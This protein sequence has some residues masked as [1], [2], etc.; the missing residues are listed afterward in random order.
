MKQPES[1]LVNIFQEGE[2]RR[3]L[4]ALLP[5]LAFLAGLILLFV[6]IFQ[7]IMVRVEGQSHSW[8]TAV[9]WTLVTM[10]TLGIG[11]VV[12]TSDIGPAFHGRR[13]DLGYGTAADLAA[14]HLHPILLRAV[15]RSASAA[16]STATR[17]VEYVWPRAHQSARRD[18]V[19]PHRA[20]HHARD[21][22]LRRGAR[23][24]R[25]GAPRQ[26]RDLGRHRRARLAHHV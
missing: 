14:V 2:M 6:A 19:R 9:Y 10:S 25:R 11:D 7:L 24:D 21:P 18:R 16:T 1:S 13:A 8:I 4:A 15:A 22:V 26:R 5:Y 3:D 20:A 12:F 23:P 17:T